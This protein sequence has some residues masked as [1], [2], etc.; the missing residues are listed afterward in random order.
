MN[1]APGGVPFEVT[2]LSSGKVLRR[3]TLPV[4]RG[5]RDM[6]IETEDLHLTPGQYKLTVFP[7]S[8]AKT[9]S[10]VFAV[11]SSPFQVKK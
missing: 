8:K 2:A 7:G 6:E 1:S 4:R 5:I 10:V 3:E 9:K 11:T